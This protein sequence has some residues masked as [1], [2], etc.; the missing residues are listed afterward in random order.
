MAE[1]P[2][3]GAIAA[4]PD[5]A[6]RTP[7]RTRGRGRG[8][9]PGGGGG[10]ILYAITTVLG[11]GLIAA[12]WFTFA[13]QEQ[14]TTAEAALVSAEGRIARLE[15]RLRL[16]DET[17]TEAGADT[18]KQLT[19]WESEIRK[20]W[21]IANKRNRGWIETNRENV[22]KL[23]T[24][25]DSAEA[26]LTALKSSVANLTAS[27]G[28][29]QEVADRVMALDANLQRLV[30]Q[31]RDLVD[32]VNAASQISA[33]LK[34]GLEAQVRDNKEAITAFD[35]QRARL[36]ADIRELRMLVEGRAAEPATPS[37]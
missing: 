37:L 29:Q 3:S 35:A 1:A 22:R 20:V 7:R 16:T 15:D 28:A 14:L 27:V 26:D 34:A 5:Q 18:N 30:R 33:S 13:Q 31:Q 11:I 6:Q 2:R 32:K 17:L 36:N 12:G 24:N 8:A 9:A 19:F 10:P 23:G 25:L 4:D 21:D